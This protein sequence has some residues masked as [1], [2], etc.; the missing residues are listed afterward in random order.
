MKKTILFME[1]DKNFLEVHARL[2][3]QAGY[4]VLKASSI[5][6]ATT[7]LA[8][9]FI[10]LA[11][12]DIRMEDDT[13]QQDIT[14]LKLAES[15]TYQAVPKIILT[16]HPSWEYAEK[17]LGAALEGLQ[18]TGM[19]KK[20]DGPDAL[21]QAVEKAF[22]NYVLVNDRLVIRWSERET[23]SFPYFITL[24]EPHLAAEDLP[25]RTGEIE[26]LFRRLFHDSHQVTISR[27]FKQGE[28]TL[29]LGL[30]T[31]NE[32]GRES[33]Y[34]VACGLKETIA[35]ERK[36]RQEVLPQATQPGSLVIEMMVETTRFAAIAYSLAGMDIT[37]LANFTTFYHYQPIEVVTNALNHLFETTL[38]AWYSKGRFHEEQKTVSTFFNEWLRLE[39][40]TQAEFEDRVQSICREIL[41]SGLAEITLL[42]H[43]W[44]WQ[45]PPERSETYPNPIPFLYQKQ[46]AFAPPYLCGTTH[47]QLSGD[48]ILINPEGQTCLI[49]FG[50]VS[51]GPL[52]RD[53]VSLETAVKFD[54]MLV[55]DAEAIY[56][57][58][59]RLLAVSCLD[60]DI[61][62]TNLEPS[63]QKALETIGRIR[64]Y[65][66]R[67]IGPE[68]EH[69]LGGLFLYAL[70]RLAAYNPNVRHTRHELI[71]LLHALLSSALICQKLT[72]PPGKNL[73]QQAI[74][75][76]WIAENDEVWVENQKITLTPREFDLLN[77]LYQRKGELCSRLDIAKTVFDAVLDPDLSH[78]HNAQL[79]APVL[80][81]TMNRLRK[82]VEI[83]PRHE[84]I[85]TER[86]KGYRLD[87]GQYS[88]H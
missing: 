58:E 46:A 56:E 30:S 38:H 81:S 60:E 62:S 9:Q 18:I 45:L 71:P 80:N 10:H 25:V 41:D 51:Q 23:L 37:E 8:E 67:V 13:D 24:L 12:L 88:N 17:T 47:G 82:K 19:V 73:P 35:N 4:E 32:L 59:K 26:A 1:D 64:H 50:Q 84:Y 29:F 22:T 52:I 66:A 39:E 15:N 79:V 11:I 33:Q 61:D 20:A 43:Q 48:S 34:I 87:L 44:Q 57:V 28:G 63:L 36:Q 27:L 21:L 49:D 78:W 40:L 65:A 16:A 2:L 69:Y 42:P 54:L 5:A 86:G 55:R 53:F 68:M 85:V 77:Y 31:Y 83:N 75:K 6:E 76:L 72:L 3:V 74:H 14:G 7:L 70:A